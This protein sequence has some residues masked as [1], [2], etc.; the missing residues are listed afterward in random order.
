M[1]II[2]EQSAARLAP[3]TSPS[4]TGERNHVRRNERGGQQHDGEARIRQHR[5]QRRD[6]HVEQR[7]AG[8]RP[9]DD[10]DAASLASGASPRQRSAAA[11]G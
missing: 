2:A 8:Q 11:R 10:L 4:A 1:F 3:S 9:G 6:D 7:I 5:E